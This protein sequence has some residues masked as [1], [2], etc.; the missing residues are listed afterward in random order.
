MIFYNTIITAIC[1]FDNQGILEVSIFNYSF[2]TARTS[3]GTAMTKF[4]SL[5]YTGPT[6]DNGHKQDTVTEESNM[7]ST[8]YD[9]LANPEA[10]G[11]MWTF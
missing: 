1:N 7:P 8:R 11:W 10:V 4:G 9:I 2:R 5:I 3:Q 6:L